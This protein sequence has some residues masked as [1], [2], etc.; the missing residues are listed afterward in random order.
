MG[1]PPAKIRSFLALSILSLMN[2]TP[3]AGCFH[4]FSLTKPISSGIILASFGFPRKRKKPAAVTL[5]AKASSEHIPIKPLSIA[6]LTSPQE[7]TKVL[8]R[9]L[10]KS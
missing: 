2:S 9:D 7:K 4:E 1:I 5:T 6:S 8:I 10:S 3:N